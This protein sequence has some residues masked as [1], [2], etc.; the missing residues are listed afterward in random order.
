MSFNIDEAIR[1]F[2][3]VDENSIESFYKR[4]GANVARIRKEKKVSQL[5]L[6][7]IMGYKSS[8]Q[9]AGSEICYKNYHFNIEQ[10]YKI[11]IILEVEMEEFLKPIK[12]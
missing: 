2:E 10:L 12:E 4:I 11:S 5:S 7:Q 3:K 6:S 8:S 9:I 1:R